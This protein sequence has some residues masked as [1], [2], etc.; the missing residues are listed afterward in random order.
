MAIQRIVRGQQHRRRADDLYAESINQRW[1]QYFL[2]QG[3]P[4]LAR[5]VGWVPRDEIRAA[6]VMQARWRAVRARRRVCPALAE[7]RAANQGANLWSVVL[8]GGWWK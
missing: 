6:V 4:N 2:D 8:G 3:K 7:A 5:K 1:I